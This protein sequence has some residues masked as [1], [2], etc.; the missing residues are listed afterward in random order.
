MPS[1]VS[2]GGVARALRTTLWE[3][4]KE[5]PDSLAP[6]HPYWRRI[7]IENVEKAAAGS[8]KIGEGLS[9]WA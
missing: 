6:R 8:E 3:C 5:V 2:N 1:G 9:L 4:Q 7:L